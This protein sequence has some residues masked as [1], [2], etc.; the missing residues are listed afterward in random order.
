MATKP[1]IDQGKRT[2]VEDYLKKRPDG[3]HEEIAQAWQD[4]KREGTVSAS[5]VGKI[6]SDLGLTR[7][8]R[9]AAQSNPEGGE[10]RKPAGSPRKRGKAAATGGSQ[11]RTNGAD[12]A[13]EPRRATVGR[14][15]RGGTSLEELEAEF[16]R[17][18]FQVM[19]QGDMPEVE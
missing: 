14:S 17:L 15:A 11:T 19:T 4:G 16:D 18:L 2:F 13:P 12:A 3:K 9:S 7:K 1:G 5:Y 8:S 10:A 6:R